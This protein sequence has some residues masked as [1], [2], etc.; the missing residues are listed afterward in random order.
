MWSQPV[1]KPVRSRLMNGLLVLTALLGGCYAEPESL[2]EAA[3]LHD[4]S[5]EP[6]NFINIDKRIP[7]STWTSNEVVLSQGERMKSG[8]SILAG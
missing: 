1:V 4:Q 7:G 8:A 6:V 2:T 5:V 3:L